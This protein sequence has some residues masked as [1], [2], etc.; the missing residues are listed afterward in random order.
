MYFFMAKK[1]NK[2]SNISNWKILGRYM[3]VQMSILMNRICTTI[4]V[5]ADQ[6][7]RAVDSNF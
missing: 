1:Q 6:I 2:L 4:Q 7:H 3:S 5:F